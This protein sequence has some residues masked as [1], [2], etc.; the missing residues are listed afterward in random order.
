MFV[1]SKR[2]MC[3]TGSLLTLAKD[4][5]NKGLQ[6]ECFDDPQWVYISW[7]EWM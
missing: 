6:Y 4:I 3:G 5:E 2:E 7:Q 1:L